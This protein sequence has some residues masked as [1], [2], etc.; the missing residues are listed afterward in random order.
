MK[1]EDIVNICKISKKPLFYDFQQD[2][3][4]IKNEKDE[5]MFAASYDI[6]GDINKRDMIDLLDIVI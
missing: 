6:L 1:K 4:V 2:S 5:I 3:C